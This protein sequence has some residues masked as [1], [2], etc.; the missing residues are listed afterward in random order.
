MALKFQKLDYPFEP[1]AMVQKYLSKI[2]MPEEQDIYEVSIK[3][4]K[5]GEEDKAASSTY[6][7]QPHLRT[8]LDSRY[9][10]KCNLLVMVETLFS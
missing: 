7:S 5:K 6:F 9:R 2:R 8:Q 10:T 3:R 4:E 1:V